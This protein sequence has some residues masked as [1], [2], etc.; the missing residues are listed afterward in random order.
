VSRR[1]A[2]RR[3]GQSL[4]LLALSVAMFGCGPA[5]Q[6]V[7]REDP[8]TRAPV[9]K[10]VVR[11]HVQNLNFNDARL[12]ALSYGSRTRL[13]I[14]QGNRDAVFSIPWDQSEPLRIEIDLL[15]GSKCTTQEID[16]DPGDTLD[17]RIQ[18]D[19]FQTSGCARG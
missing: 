8:F 19:L 17:L 10:E 7:Q 16:V 18:A 3:G 4:A 2:L 5:G 13:G 15:A 14:V 1:P 11:L 9:E 6:L 12:F